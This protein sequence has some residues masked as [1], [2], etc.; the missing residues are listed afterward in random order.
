M[1]RGEVYISGMKKGESRKR[2]EERVQSFLKCKQN[3]VIKRFSS[4][5]CKYLK[6]YKLKPELTDFTGTIDIK[7]TG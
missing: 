6:F 4:V 7:S 5:T 2:E 1:G 3:K